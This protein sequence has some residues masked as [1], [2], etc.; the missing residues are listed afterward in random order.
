MDSLNIRY[1]FNPALTDTVGFFDFC[2]PLTNESMHPVAD[3]L[4][5]CYDFSVYDYITPPPAQKD[6]IQSTSIFSRHQLQPV[7]SGEMPVNRQSTDWITAL[8]LVCLFIFAWIQTYYSKRLSQVFRAVAQ[9][10]AVNQ[11]EREG[12]LFSE[13]ITLGLAFIYYT[14]CSIFIYQVFSEFFT[15]PTGFTNLTFTLLIYGSLFTYQMIKSLIVY[16]MG[17]VFTN[18][19]SARS[20]Q[21]NTLMFNHIIGTLLFPFTIMAFYWESTL[22]LN[23]GII[24]ISLLL[25]YRLF[26][27]I[28]IGLANKN[29][30]LFYL[31]LYLCTLEILPLLLLYKVISKI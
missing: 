31:F 3:S 22:F 29:Y 30:N 27:G 7:H 1:Q 6:L 18:S 4:K 10:H 14:V 19:E 28:L 23:I 25:L 8:L 13:R 26:R 11:L 17:I 20:F 21:L 15:L 12:N 9:A 16:T 5:K 2:I 24:I